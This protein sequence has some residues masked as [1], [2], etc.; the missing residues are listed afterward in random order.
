MIK[1]TV[2]SNVNFEMFIYFETDEDSVER[3]DGAKVGTSASVEAN[4]T[5]DID[6]SNDSDNKVRSNCSSKTLYK[7]IHILFDPLGEFIQHS[8]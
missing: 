8:K 7:I 3:A 2:A 1:T 5:A 6:E 4:A